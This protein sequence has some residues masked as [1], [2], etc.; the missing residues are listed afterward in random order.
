[1]DMRIKKVGKWFVTQKK[2]KKLFG[3][4]KWMYVNQD[5]NL[6]DAIDRITPKYYY[7]PDFKETTEER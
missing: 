6:E 4:H 7:P 5:D 3:R 2:V 1:M